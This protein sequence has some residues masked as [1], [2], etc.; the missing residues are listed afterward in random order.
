VDEAGDPGPG[1]GS[2]EGCGAVSVD[3]QEVRHSSGGDETGDVKDDLGARDEG[4]EGTLVV[5][6]PLH[7]TAAGGP[8]RPRHR[9]T[10][11]Q[12][13]DLVA[14]STER[15]EEMR[16]DEAG[17]PGERNSHVVPGMGLS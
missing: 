6:V 14:T 16:A 2:R 15:L 17:G 8:K 5:E 13:H 1:R 11:D 4:F 10:P 9:R 12:G 7:E 3:P